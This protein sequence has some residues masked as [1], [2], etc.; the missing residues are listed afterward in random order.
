MKALRFLLIPLL[1]CSI[2]AG[3]L[4][5]HAQ[6]RTYSPDQ[7]TQ[8]VAPIAL[9]PD[10]LMSQVLMAS[11]YPNQVVETDQWVRANPGLTGSALDSALATATWDPS[12]IS[13]SK[14]PTVLDRMAQN[15]TWTTDLG[16]AFLY[17]RTDV[18][19]AVQDLRSAAY[20][21]GTLRTTEQERVVV[22]GPDIVIQP[23][24]PEV[25]YVPV[26]QPSVVYGSYWNYPSYYYPGVWDPWP[27]YSFIN[28]FAW[29]IGYRL[30]QHP[31]RRVRLGPPRRVDGLRRHQ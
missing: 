2:L 11:T 12:V 27:G 3:G 19:D 28:G 15:I 14:F 13:L 4:S 22:E 29:G 30:R 21:N 16:N 20:Q 26:Y 1:G 10:A 7:V 8:M 6:G 5:L 9:Y 24:T 31:L 23:S 17:Q 25:I 18:M